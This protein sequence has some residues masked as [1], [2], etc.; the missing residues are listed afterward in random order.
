MTPQP[1]GEFSEFTIRR[2]LAVPAER[3]WLTVTDW[4]AHARWVPATTVRVTTPDP[5]GVGTQFIARTGL[6]PLAMVDVMRVTR[7][8][9][10]GPGI[11]GE[12]EIEKIGGLVKGG[13]RIAVTAAGPDR[14]HLVWGEWLRIKGLSAIPGARPVMA[15]VARVAFGRAISAM[16]AEMNAVD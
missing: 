4:A 3:L 10:P 7:W 9:P 12:C 1:A 11:P 16:A 2:T 6:G 14:S 15:V 8:Q 5:P 13:A